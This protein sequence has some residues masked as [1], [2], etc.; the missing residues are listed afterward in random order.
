MTH[1][2]K[3]KNPKRITQTNW[4]FRNKIILECRRLGTT[5]DW[6]ITQSPL[7]V[8]DNWK[9]RYS[10]RFTNKFRPPFLSLSLV[11]YTSAREI[12][13]FWH[14]RPRSQR[15]PRSAPLH[16]SRV[17]RKRSCTFPP[18]TTTLL[19]HLP[20]LCEQFWLFHFLFHSH[21]LTV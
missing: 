16:P 15:M 19:T 18:G 3:E 12:I 10:F 8:I 1:G 4:H 6:L 11:T 21:S 5:P 9:S 17:L 14:R 7:L 13:L 2:G 20:L